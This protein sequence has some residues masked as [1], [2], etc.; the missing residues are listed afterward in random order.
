MITIQIS[1]VMPPI[2]SNLWSPPSQDN[3]PLIGV[4]ILDI[5]PI[6]V[7]RDVDMVEGKTTLVRSTLQNIGISSKNITVKLYFEGNLKSSTNDTINSGQTKY[8]NLFFIPDDSG[9]SKEVKIRV[10]GNN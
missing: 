5:L 6:Q 4:R 3:Y 9:I 2:I 10:E 1:L 8:I 7:V